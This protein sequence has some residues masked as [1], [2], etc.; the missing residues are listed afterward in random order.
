MIFVRKNSDEL[1]GLKET[2]RRYFKE[3]NDSIETSNA[4]LSSL[5]KDRSI[6]IDKA[7]KTMY[8][9]P[10]MNDFFRS[11]SVTWKTT[12]RVIQDSYLNKVEPDTFEILFLDFPKSR[13]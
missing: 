8:W 1:S 2:D 4:T 9:D 10:D 13:K 3:Y 11:N 12:L 7:N 5:F 6:V